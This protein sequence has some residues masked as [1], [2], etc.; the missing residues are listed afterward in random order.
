MNFIAIDLQMRIRKVKIWEK[1]LLIWK[2]ESFWLMNFNA[3][4]FQMR[5]ST[6]KFWK[7]KLAHVQR[8]VPT[9]QSGRRYAA[10]PLR[11][12]L[13]AALGRLRKRITRDHR[14][15]PI[16]SATAF[17]KLRKDVALRIVIQV[18]GAI[19]LERLQPR[20]HIL[21]APWLEEDA[22]ILRREAHLR[23]GQSRGAFEPR[24]GGLQP[25]P[26]E[27]APRLRQLEH[28]DAAV[29]GENTADYMG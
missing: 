13:I 2:L 8:D 1:I 27:I 3:I 5:N 19:Q 7:K 4:D 25:A 15:G 12:R 22:Q 11:K 17:E 18:A 26:Q 9:G 28:G 21:Q 23:I 20:R 29:R 10:S 24:T 6:V 14:R 16:H